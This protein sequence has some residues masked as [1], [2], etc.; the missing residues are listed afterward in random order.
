V[1]K[2]PVLGQAVDRLKENA[3]LNITLTGSPTDPDVAVERDK[4]AE[5]IREGIRETIR[6]IR[7]LGDRFGL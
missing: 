5:R 3:A 4:P 2:L 6:D 7:G 1:Q